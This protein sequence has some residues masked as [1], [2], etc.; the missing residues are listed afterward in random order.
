MSV[1]FAY[2]D[3]SGSRSSVG[4]KARNSVLACVVGSPE[5]LKE[6]AE[7][8]RRLKLN[9]RPHADPASWEL[10][11]GD[12]LHGRDRSP[13]GSMGM[14]KKMSVMRKIV[15]IVCDCDIVVFGTVV[16][17]KRARGKKAV[18]TKV[19]E[20]A[21]AILVGRLGRFAKE[22]DKGTTLHVVS[23]NMPETH[24]LAMKRA[25]VGSDLQ[26]VTDIKF[27]D[28]RSGALI[29]VVDA[30]AYIINRHIAGDPEF[31]EMFED[32][33]RKAWTRSKC[34]LRMWS[35]QRPDNPGTAVPSSTLPAAAIL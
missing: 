18:D 6:L 15:D 10:H 33:R 8:I 11:T 28:S 32:I 9:L 27:V 17:A 1:W 19:T 7:R 21:T 24:R 22:L 30:I 2:V 26:R 14:D 35:A 5:S 34:G 23:D 12:M 13:L 25:L 29:Q 20:C 3:E 16:V 4:G 31:G